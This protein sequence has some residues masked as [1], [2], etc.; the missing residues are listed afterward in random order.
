MLYNLTMECTPKVHHHHMQ[1]RNKS[2]HG[3]GDPTIDMKTLISN[4]VLEVKI[5]MDHPEGFI[6]EGNEHLV[7]KLK[8]ACTGSNNR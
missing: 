8:E 2:G 3:L 4:R 5:Y 1:S 7:C 6:Q